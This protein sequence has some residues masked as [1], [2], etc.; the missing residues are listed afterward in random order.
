MPDK[1]NFPHYM[2]KEILD[3]P[4]ALR[5]TIAPRVSQERAEV[6][7]AEE[8]RI[9]EA[10]LRSL[11]RIHI[12]ASGTSRHAGIAGQFMFQ[13]L[14]HLPVEVDYA[15]EFEYRDPLIGGREITI[16]ITQ[17]GETADTT[18]AQREAKEKASRTIAISNVVGSTIAREADGVLYTHA[19]PEISIA[20][21]K[22]FTAQMAVLFLLAA[23]IAQVRGV[24]S[25]NERRRWIAE[26][27]A[28]P[29]KTE[30][31]LEH[32]AECK[33]LADRFHNF[34]DFLFLGRAI[35]Y[36]VAMDGALKLKEVSY[37][38][39]EGYP[40]GETKH[41]PNALIDE[42]LPIVIVATCDRNDPGSVVRYEKNVANIRGFKQ[43]S[44][45]VIAIATEGDTELPGLADHVIFVPQAPELLSPILEIVPLQL[46]AYYMAV[47]KGLDVDRPRNL[48]K[49]VTLE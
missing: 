20:S 21:T 44:A 5:D 11:Q 15:S 31:V 23:Y 49:S 9:S 22:A 6:R 16:V 29:K 13:E 39:A 4:Q 8:V 18:A 35:H 25:E 43:Q 24:L 32:A 47:R 38:H 30:T 42:N 12:V 14:V 40:T 19:G 37:I 41:G 10:E 28:L 17:S 7:L 1:G 3:Q 26:L 2:L 48:V 46:F 45:R 34:A 36:P 27:L 33:L